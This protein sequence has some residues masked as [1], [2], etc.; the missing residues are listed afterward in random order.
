LHVPTHFFFEGKA[1]DALEVRG[2]KGVL[3]EELFVVALDG[4]KGI[5]LRYH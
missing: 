2:G 4:E 1:E 5:E 3:G